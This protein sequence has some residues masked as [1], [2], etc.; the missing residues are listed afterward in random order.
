MQYILIFLILG[1]AILLAYLINIPIKNKHYLLIVIN[2]VFDDYFSYEGNSTKRFPFIYYI[3][4]HNAEANNIYVK[5]IMENLNELTGR[6]KNYDSIYDLFKLKRST[7]QFRAD[8]EKKLLDKM[9]N[10]MRYTFNNKKDFAE[11]YNEYK[12]LS[13]VQIMQYKSSIRVNYILA[14]AIA[15]VAII[16]II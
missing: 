15:M 8:E 5:T 6:Y 12:E 7:N 9:L 3:K 13:S 11:R 4:K 10:I 14:I 16:L 2:N 1:G